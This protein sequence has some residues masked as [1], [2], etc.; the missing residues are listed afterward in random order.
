MLVLTRGSNEAV[1]MCLP[2]G[3]TITVTVCDI[4][5]DNKVRIGFDAPDEIKIV[6]SELS[7]VTK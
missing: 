6:R 5:S 1:R 2:D 3:Q 4:R 7:N